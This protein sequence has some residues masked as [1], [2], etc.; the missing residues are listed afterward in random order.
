ML[1]VSRLRFEEL[2]MAFSMALT[3]VSER[4]ETQRLRMKA[5]Q[6]VLDERKVAAMDWAGLS[7]ETEG[8][9]QQRVW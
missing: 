4:S 5:G 1:M 3:M 6:E 7:R 8:R 2:S 9:Q